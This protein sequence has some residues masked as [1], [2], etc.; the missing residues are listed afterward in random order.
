MTLEEAQQVAERICN[1]Y[2]SNVTLSEIKQALVLLG[3]F[4]EDNKRE[5]KEER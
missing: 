1:F 2:S 4:Y 3:N 5:A